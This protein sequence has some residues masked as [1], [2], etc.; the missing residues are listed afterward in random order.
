MSPFFNFALL[1]NIL[2]CSFFVPA[3]S[4]SVSGN[5][6][7][8]SSGQPVRL[9]GVNRSGMEFMCIQGYGFF[10]GPS[11]Q[12]SINAMKTWNITI[13]RV[14][15]NEDCWLN[16]NGV[17]PEYGGQNYI[18]AVT[19]YVNLLTSNQLAVIIDLHWSASGSTPATKQTPMPDQDHAGQFWDS[20]ARTFA[21]N[22]DVIF[23][24]FNEPYPDNNNWN[25]VAGWTCWRD[26]GSACNGLDYTAVGMQSLVTQVRNTGARNVIML[27]GLAYSNSVAQWLAYKPKDP[28]NFTA[29]SLHVYNFNYCSTIACYDQYIAPVAAQVPVIIG[30]S[31]ENDCNSGFV[32]TLMTWA[33]S[34]S[35][36]YLG[37]TWNTWDCGSGPALISNYDGTPTNYGLGLRKHLTGR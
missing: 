23:D 7:V 18:N 32:E 8:N 12:N 24:I 11:D 30:E 14:P 21:G 17:K 5:R 2:V 15:L 25:S 4:L 33:D 10:D 19:G 1:V 27:G 20:V 16:I 29:A 22:L 3:L 31:G 36:G 9:V 6:I 28:L 35:I 13:V 26:G 37:W 34:K